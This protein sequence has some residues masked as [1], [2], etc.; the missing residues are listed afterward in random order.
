MT[1]SLIAAIRS[2]CSRRSS[3]SRVP[4]SRDG[5]SHFQQISEPYSPL[6]R[7]SR[8]PI[9]Y[10]CDCQDQPQSMASFQE[11]LCHLLPRF[12][13]QSSLPASPNIHAYSWCSG[14]QRASHGEQVSQVGK[15]DASHPQLILKPIKK[16]FESQLLQLSPQVNWHSQRG[17]DR[18]YSLRQ[19]SF[20]SAASPVRY[21]K[22]QVTFAFWT[23]TIL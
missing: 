7:R 22:Q 1:K 2:T 11:L 19:V 6:R 20:R 14:S 17:H 9:K 23:S 4:C 8:L 16:S 5:R 18:N 10:P 13:L 12:S 15:L 3:G 21:R